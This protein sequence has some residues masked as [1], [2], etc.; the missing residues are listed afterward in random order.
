MKIIFATHNDNK[1]K[2]VRALL[3][4]FEV[5]SLGDLGYKQDIPEIGITLQENA[6]I[7]SKTIFDEFK[8]PVIADD[9]GLEVKAL[10]GAPG[11]YSARYA[12]EP[13]N[14]EKNMQ[15]LLQNLEG[16]EQRNAAFITVISYIPKD[17]VELLFEG[18][19]EGEIL[20]EKRGEKGF[21][22]DPIFKPK[23]YELSFAEMSTKEKNKISHRARAL[24][25]FV[26]FIQKGVQKS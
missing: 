1:T 13:A 5:L 7:K 25:A 15:K 10:N 23:D 3:P 2:E 14:S 6:G 22:Y 16:V 4:S 17:G 18:T 20:K 19:V 9:T 11:V 26:D 24:R 8:L 21:G 12:G